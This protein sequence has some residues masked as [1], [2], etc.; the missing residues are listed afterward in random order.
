MVRRHV[1]APGNVMTPPLKDPPTRLNR[2]CLDVVSVVGEPELSPTIEAN[3]L[4]LK[5]TRELGLVEEGGSSACV[6]TA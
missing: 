4:G 2:P 1:K 5:G 3:P 6:F